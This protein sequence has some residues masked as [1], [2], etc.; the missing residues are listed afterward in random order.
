MTDMPGGALRAR[1][2]APPVR[3]RLTPGEIRAALPP[4]EAAAFD[5]QYRRALAQASDGDDLTGV[6]ALLK[7]WRTVASAG[8][9]RDDRRG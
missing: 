4:E 1:G 8:S 5:V 2:E 9:A 7:R 6:L 3:R